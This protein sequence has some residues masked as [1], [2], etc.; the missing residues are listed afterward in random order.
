MFFFFRR[1]NY[2]KFLTAQNE[3]NKT[4]KVFNKTKIALERAQSKIV[5]LIADSHSTIDSYNAA[6]ENEKLFIDEMNKEA[7]KNKKM[8]EQIKPFLGDE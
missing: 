7:E 4:L 8:Q 3:V 1:S 6:I 2:K 5:N